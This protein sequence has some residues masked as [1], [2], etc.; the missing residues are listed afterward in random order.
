MEEVGSHCSSMRILLTADP[1]IPVPPLH[2]GG[3]ERIIDM[4]IRG[5]RDR[6]HEVLLMA[7]PDSQPDCKVVAWPGLDVRG[8]WDTMRNIIAVRKAVASFRPDI[9]HSFGRLVYLTGILRSRLPKVMSYQREPSLGQIT[10][11]VSLARPGT[12][13]FTGCAEH[14]AV[15]IRPI[16]T[17]VPIYNGVPLG[18]Y[19]FRPEVASDAPLV[20]L[21]RI[22]PIKG[23][24]EAIDVAKRSG[25]RLVIAGNVSSEGGG[26]A[27]FRDQIEPQI[28]GDQIQYVGPVDDTQKNVLLG[29]A[30]AFLMPIQW[31]EPFGIVMAEALACGTPII[32]TR[33]GSVPEVVIEGTNGFVRSD[34]DGMVEAVSRLGQIDRSRCRLDCEQRFSDT[35]IVDA[36]LALYEQRISELY[37]QVATA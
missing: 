7:H 14:I 3:I 28:D 27:Y 21:G 9:V 10:K 18:T 12:L 33:R 34:V 8:K 1:M 20:F 25:R 4:L 2:Y 24:R 19:T 31:E 30:A 5:Y 11:A 29:G 37:G 26:E 16:A 6:G 22:E 35:A 15:K 23:T 36:Y 13:T 17:S 32:G